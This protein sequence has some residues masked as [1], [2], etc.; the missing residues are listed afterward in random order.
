MK[1]TTRRKARTGGRIVPISQWS[2][3]ST[4]SWRNSASSLTPPSFMAARRKHSVKTLLAMADKFAERAKAGPCVNEHSDPPRGRRRSATLALRVA[5][6]KSPDAPGRR[7]RAVAP[8][9]DGRVTFAGGRFE[10]LIVKD[11]DLAATVF[12]Q[13]SILQRARGSRH[14][15]PSHP[16]HVGEKFLSQAKFSGSHP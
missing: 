1:S 8:A 4:G 15:D 12:D 7:V 11:T 13:L 2:T 9:V 16:Q 3:L 6:L 14:A 10:A 5:L